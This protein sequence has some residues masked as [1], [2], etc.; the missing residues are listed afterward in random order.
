[1]AKNWNIMS[2]TLISNK[3]NDLDWEPNSVVFFCPFIN[4]LEFH[5]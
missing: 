4:F 5:I 2:V 3:E 1:M